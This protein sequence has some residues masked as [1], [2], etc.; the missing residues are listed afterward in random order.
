MACAS[1]SLEGTKLQWSP[2]RCVSVMLASGGYPDEHETGFEISGV[3]E[4][5]STGALVFHAGTTMTDGRLETSGGR[6][7][8]VS[9]LGPSFETARSLAYDA[10]SKI[11]FEGRH[12]RTD[13]AARAVDAERNGR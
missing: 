7:V 5:E 13:I 6:V 1:G 11:H 8:A 10:A 12:M 4:A 3:A 2:E 9:A